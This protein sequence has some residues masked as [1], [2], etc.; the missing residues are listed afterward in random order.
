MLPLPT[1]VFAAMS[2][3]KT[4][5]PYIPATELLWVVGDR[6][7][8]NEQGRVPTNRTRRNILRAEAEHGSHHAHS[9]QIMATL[10]AL[11]HDIG[12]ATQGFQR[13]LNPQQRKIQA[14]DPYRHEWISLRLFQ[15]MIHGCATDAEWL[16]RLAQW[17]DYAQAQPDWDSRI[18]NDSHA[19]ASHDFSVAPPLAQWLMWL[20]VTHH[21]LP[22]Y[23]LEYHAA[24]QRQK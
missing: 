2:K 5:T 16:A 6:R 20:I 13:K 21:R 4:K 15:A 19:K 8:F 14:G 1:L 23:N 18:I 7:Q 9:I 11:L 3:A 24:S 17:R 12:K 10:A 22:F